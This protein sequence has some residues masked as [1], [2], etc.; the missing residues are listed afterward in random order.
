M[1]LIAYYYCTRYSQNRPE[2]TTSALL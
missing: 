2:K 1:T